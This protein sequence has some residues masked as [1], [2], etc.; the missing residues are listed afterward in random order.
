MPPRRP[1]STA[2]RPHTSHLL[3]GTPPTGHTAPPTPLPRPQAFR[4]RL[5][6]L[7]SQDPWLRCPHGSPGPRDGCSAQ[8][9]HGMR[10]RGPPDARPRPSCPE[11]P[12]ACPHPR[13]LGPLPPSSSAHHGQGR[14]GRLRS[15]GSPA[16]SSAPRLLLR[17]RSPAPRPPPI[18]GLTGAHRQV[19]RSER[20][21]AA[22]PGPL[23]WDPTLVPRLSQ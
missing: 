9:R 2:F 3:P 17:P 4:S 20:C 1:P 11:H 21:G 18:A 10:P 16:L 7:P 15:Q 13:L 6:G 5:A 22:S 8:E 14:G 23:L 19:R 12:R